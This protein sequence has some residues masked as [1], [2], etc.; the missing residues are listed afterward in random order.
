V[1]KWG[2][3]IKIKC[4]RLTPYH[5]PLPGYSQFYDVKRRYFYTKIEQC[6]KGSDGY[7]SAGSHK[8]WAAFLENC[9]DDSKR[10]PVPDKTKS[11]HLTPT[12]L[13]RR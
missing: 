11:T 4:T 1:Y 6:G 12:F 13:A 7:K 2:D 10:N 8:K 5:Y 9:G 3:I